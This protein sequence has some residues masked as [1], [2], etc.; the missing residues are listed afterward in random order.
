MSTIYSIKIPTS[1]FVDFLIKEG[2]ANDYVNHVIDYAR[3][4]NI[5]CISALQNHVGSP[6]PKSFSSAFVWS[7]TDQ[8]RRYWSKINIK[9]IRFIHRYGEN[10]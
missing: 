9:W 1:I 2:V 10:M 4:N 7:N 6:S 3:S 8:G 5:D